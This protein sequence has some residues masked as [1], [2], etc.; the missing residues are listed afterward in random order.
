MRNEKTKSVNSIQVIRSNRKTMALEV[1]PDCTVLV[2]AP[3]YVSAE[4]VNSFVNAHAD[5]IEKHL[6][7]AEE[8]LK[9]ADAVPKLSTDEMYELAEKA[10]H[11]IPNKVRDYAFQMNISYGRITIRNQRTR[12]GSCSSKGNL[13]F[14]CLLMLC[15]EYVIDYVV[16][17]ELCHRV[18]MNHSKR[19]W[20]LVEKAMPD[21]K[22]AKGWLKE[23]GN[24]IMSQ[25]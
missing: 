23:H 6:K 15:P 25:M 22:K 13:N 19:F 16:I 18:E 8:K 10:L 11:V 1:R 4:S 24:E 17:H 21:Y 2:R 14:N 3:R 12:W 7:I 20:D 9:N 5:W